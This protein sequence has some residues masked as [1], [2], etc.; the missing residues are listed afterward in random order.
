MKLIEKEERQDITS[1][2]ESFDIKMHYS[3]LLLTHRSPSV[4]HVKVLIIPE[5]CYHGNCDQ[6]FISLVLMIEK[7]QDLKGLTLSFPLAYDRISYLVFSLKDI[8]KFV[9]SLKFTEEDE[10]QLDEDEYIQEKFFVRKIKQ[11]SKLYITWKKKI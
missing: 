7:V 11:D 9:L 5:R 10:K 6:S 2:K 4:L 8:I 3:P 1:L